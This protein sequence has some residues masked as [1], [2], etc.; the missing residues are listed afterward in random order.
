MK[1]STK[2]RYALRL[3]IDIALNS[4][5]SNVALKDIS[6][7]QGI[8]VKYLEQIISL[9]CKVGFL[10]STRGPK[11]GYILAKEPKEYTVGSILRITEGKLAPVSCLEDEENK[12]AMCYDCATIDFWEGFY[13]VINQYVD[14][15]TLQD[16]LDKHQM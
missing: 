7:R 3:M 10:R 1:I 13:N 5:G 9:L 4:N 11:G 8:S 14:K 15:Y 16:L 6:A 2:G 12:C